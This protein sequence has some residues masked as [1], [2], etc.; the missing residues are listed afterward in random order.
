MNKPLSEEWELNNNL[1][2]IKQY[3]IYP[4]R[5]KKNF[6]FHGN[7]IDPVTIKEL[8]VYET[9]F[10]MK[11]ILFDLF[12]DFLKDVKKAELRTYLEQLENTLS[13]FNTYLDS[14]I[15]NDIIVY[16]GSPLS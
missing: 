1:E 2:D 7:N 3:I 16:K 11:G 9:K 4:Y 8:H 10:S 5:N 13:S 6:Y 15:Q 14:Y 12:M